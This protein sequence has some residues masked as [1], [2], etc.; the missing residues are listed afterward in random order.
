MKNLDGNHTTF[1]PGIPGGPD[2]PAR[3]L[4]PKL[5]RPGAPERPFCPEVKEGQIM[6]LL[7]T[8]K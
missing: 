8:L 2:G 4:T 3:P 1:G 6:L 7:I 5:F